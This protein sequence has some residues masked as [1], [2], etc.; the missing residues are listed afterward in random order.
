MVPSNNDWLYM[1]KKHLLNTSLNVNTDRSLWL[2]TNAN[3]LYLK[4]PQ[5]LK[6]TQN[7]S[8]CT[9]MWCPTDGEP[10]IQCQ[11]EKAPFLLSSRC[12]RKYL[13]GKGW[14][15]TAPLSGKI[16]ACAGH[17]R[18]L[19][20]WNQ[21]PISKIQTL[22]LRLPFH[23]QGPSVNGAHKRFCLTAR[24]SPSAV[25]ITSTHKEFFLQYI[26]FCRNS[27][28]WLNQY[29]FLHRH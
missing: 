26:P 29:L 8:V 2:Q 10:W 28:V 14:Y 9:G 7:A 23:S 1:R 12:D 3:S 25:F 18:N 13:E 17:S 11:L 5:Y 24:T 21:S 6:H 19:W 20:V 22:R 15:A 4:R 16:L 27:L